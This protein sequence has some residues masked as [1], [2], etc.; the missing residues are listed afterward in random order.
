MNLN[1]DFVIYHIQ[2]FEIK[3]RIHIAENFVICLDNIFYV[4]V[5]EV[6][7]RVDVLLHKPAHL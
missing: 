3:H 5:D 6:I 1:S 7:E 2:I 4:Y